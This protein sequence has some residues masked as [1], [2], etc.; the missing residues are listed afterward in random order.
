MIEPHL[1]WLQKEGGKQEDSLGMDMAEEAAL[2]AAPVAEATVDEAAE[3]TES[4]ALEAAEAAEE[5]TELACRTWSG[6]ALTAPMA[7]SAI[8]DLPYMFAVVFELSGLVCVICLS[9]EKMGGGKERK[10]ERKVAQPL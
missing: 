8:R 2:E 10:E 9:L 5:A 4:T 1:Q 7:A 3:M 6:L